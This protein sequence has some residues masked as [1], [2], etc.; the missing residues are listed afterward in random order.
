MSINLS[1]FGIFLLIND[2]TDLNVFKIEKDLIV[3]YFKFLF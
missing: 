3:P 1:F 2:E